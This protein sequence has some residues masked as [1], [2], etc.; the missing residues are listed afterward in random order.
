VLL[1]IDGIVLNGQFERTGTAVSM[2]TGVNLAVGS[3]EFEVRDASDQQRVITSLSTRHQIEVSQAD[4]SVV[5]FKVLSNS[6]SSMDNGSPWHHTAEVEQAETVI[7]D[8]IILD[9]LTLRPYKYEE[10]TEDGGIVIDARVAVDETGR[11]E[12]EKRLR[13]DDRDPGRYFDVVRKGV[14]DTPRQMRFGRCRWSEHGDETK[15]DLILVERSV[16]GNK[17][18][19]FPEFYPEIPNMRRAIALTGNLVAELLDTLVESGSLSVEQRSGV[20]ARAEAALWARH[21]ALFKL[22]DI[23]RHA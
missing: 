17:P 3:V 23:D 16:D 13:A 8:E 7:P 2:H 6:Y 20:E 4:E 14:Q 11:Q 21:W 18:E 22:D 9:G 5:R 15:Y 19:P 12:V 10:R 1:R